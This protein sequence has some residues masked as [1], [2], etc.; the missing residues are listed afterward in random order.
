MFAP[1]NR[2]TIKIIKV[3]IKFAKLFFRNVFSHNNCVKSVNTIGLNSIIQ[4]AHA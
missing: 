3:K 1:E 2:T 4:Y